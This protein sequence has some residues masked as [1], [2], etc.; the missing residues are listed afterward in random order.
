M[1]KHFHDFSPTLQCEVA[2]VLVLV[3]TSV[4]RDDVD[5]NIGNDGIA[6]VFV[7]QQLSEVMDDGEA[8][9][10]VMRSRALSVLTQ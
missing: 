1:R 2:P 3:I 5:Y 8:F 9:H 6:G 7:V 4:N 10:I